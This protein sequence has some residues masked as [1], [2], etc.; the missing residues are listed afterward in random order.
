MWININFLRYFFKVGKNLN[1]L[2]YYVLILKNN[3]N[4]DPERCNNKHTVVF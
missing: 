1:F 3:L 4:S 2:I